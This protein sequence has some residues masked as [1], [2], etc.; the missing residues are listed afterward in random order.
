MRLAYRRITS[1]LPDFPLAPAG[2]CLLEVTQVVSQQAIAITCRPLLDP[3][4][5]LN[6]L[7][8]VF[9]DHSQYIKGI[10]AQPEHLQALLKVHPTALT[11]EDSLHAWH[12]SC[13]LPAIMDTRNRSC[14][15]G[16]GSA[17]P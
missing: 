12:V 10:A 14:F 7:L 17:E 9:A 15:T 5:D 16:A 4:L 8:L 11:C 6:G 2:H 1:Y 3:L 13:S